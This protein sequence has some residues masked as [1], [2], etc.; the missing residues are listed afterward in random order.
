[1]AY[2]GVAGRERRRRYVCAIFLISFFLPSLSLLSFR[3]FHCDSIFAL[4]EIR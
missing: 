1:M 3:H 4:S 2:A